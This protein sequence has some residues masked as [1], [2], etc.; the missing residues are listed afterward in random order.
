M[1]TLRNR[2]CLLACLLLCGCSPLMQGSI[3]TFK[4]SV[5]NA[6]PLQLTAA[7]VAA[8][9]YAQ[10]LVTTPSS[11]GVMAKVRQQG[12]L[13]F[14]V[15]S[16]KQVLLMRDGLIVRSVGLEPSLDGTRFDG[17]SPFKRGLQH[18][19]DGETSTRWIDMYKGE[20][21]GLAVN[22]RFRRKGLETVT[23]LGKPHAVQRI[24][25]A[26]EI[27]A[28]GF[29]A[30]NRFWVRPVDGLVLQSQQYLTPEL[31]LKIVHLR[32]DWETAR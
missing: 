21:V 27:P 17:E 15:A 28:L 6:E 2:S 23:I 1:K 30:T 11:Q 26:F 29:S 18:I 24:D 7:D 10:I 16:G 4:A 5:L 12:D 9:P 32:P 14:W 25:E 8:V 3:D 13:Q 22:S 20:Q 19:A 31:A